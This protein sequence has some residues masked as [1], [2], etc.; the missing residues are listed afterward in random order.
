MKRFNKW[1]LGLY[2][3]A[4]FLA[5]GGTGAFVT[6]RL[7]RHLM[8]TTPNTQELGARLKARFR[9]RLELTPGQAALVDPWVDQAMSQ[10]EI[11]HQDMAARI[12]ANVSNLNFQVARDL[13]PE[14]KLK[15]EE[16]DRERREHLRKKLGPP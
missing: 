10:V 7:T 16:Y 6:W 8:F 9:S 1:K 14:Q 12:F 11:I 2:V 5:G 15:L 13:T 4:I 3:A